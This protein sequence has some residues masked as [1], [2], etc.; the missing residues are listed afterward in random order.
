LGKAQLKERPIIS[1]KEA[2]RLLGKEAKGLEDFEIIEII[3]S[4]TALAKYK[5]KKKSVKKSNNSLEL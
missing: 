1:V 3:N 2:R 5:L 4:L